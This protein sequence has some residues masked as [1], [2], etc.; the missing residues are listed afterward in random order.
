MKGCSRQEVFTGEEKG[1]WKTT[2]GTFTNYI[3][4]PGRLQAGRWRTGSPLISPQ[5]I[6]SQ[7]TSKQ[8]VQGRA[9][10]WELLIVLSHTVQWKPAA[11]AGWRAAISCLTL[12]PKHAVMRRR[13]TIHAYDVNIT[14]YHL[15]KFSISKYLW[16]GHSLYQCVINEHAVTSF[17]DSPNWL[18][19]QCLR[20]RTVSA[21]MCWK[22]R[23]EAHEWKAHFWCRW[24]SSA[25]GLNGLIPLDVH[26]RAVFGARPG[27]NWVYWV[28]ITKE[29]PDLVCR[30]SGSKPQLHRF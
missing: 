4:I 5:V 11:G 16:N 9:L 25:A 15:F 2:L 28:W 30:N 6:L 17:N 14:F 21:I 22:A 1:F 27:F 7:R 10:E 24:S 18:V 13:N 23:E 20:V 29:Y 26:R 19:L 3:P 8:D 12:Y